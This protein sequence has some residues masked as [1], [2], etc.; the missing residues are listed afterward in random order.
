MTDTTPATPGSV[1]PR[2]MFPPLYLD[3]ARRPGDLLALHK[4]GLPQLPQA[5]YA[6]HIAYVSTNSY[7][8]PIA[9]SG[10]VLAPAAATAGAAPM[11]VYCPSF[12]GLGGPCAPSQLLMA[13]DEPEAA[14]L[15]A[16]L[17]R[18]WTVAV[19]DGEGLGIFGTG[20]HTFLA[21]RAA[22]HVAL[23]MARA[24]RRL[25]DL[26]ASDS[27]IG[28][29]GYADGGRA[30]IAAGELCAEYAPELDLRAV[31]AGAVVSDPGELAP[32]LDGGPWSGLVFA[33]LIGL[34]CAHGH[35]PVHHV[36][37]VDGLRTIGAAES[38]TASQLYEQ[39]RRAV[40]HWCERD[41]PWNDPLWRLVFARERGGLGGPTVPVHLYHG[42]RDGLVPVDQGRRLYEDYRAL[43]ADVHWRDYPTG[44]FA[45][46]SAGTVDA[47]DF[48]SAA[49]GH[50]AT[51]HPG[52]TGR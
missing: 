24:T 31:A 42:T 11:L 21:S 9:V 30:A 36:L 49:L 34:R 20:P 15:G 29:W 32:R 39:Y 8:R 12:H 40:G 33:G 14:R 50:P 37:T 23:D 35:I 41:D 5:V 3:D 47:L 1:L 27:P 4:V 25:P 18:G 2:G 44:H 7:D 10:T 51:A 48:L 43:G 22:G 16:A 45:A 38:A 17:A 6:W 28:V 13:G 46:A 52:D 26:D 19:P